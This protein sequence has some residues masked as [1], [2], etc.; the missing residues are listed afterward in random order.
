MTARARS[1]V[2]SERRIAAWAASV[3]RALRSDEAWAILDADPATA[4]GTW[5]HG[6]CLLLAKA[7]RATLGAGEV[8]IVTSPRRGPGDRVEHA[9]LRL[10]N[11]FVDAEGV[12]SE[13]ALLGRMARREMI[14]SP[15][16]RR[17]EQGDV[18][19]SDVAAPRASVAALAALLAD[20]MKLPR[21]NGA[22]ATEREPRGVRRAAV[23]I[24]ADGVSDSHGVV[25]FLGRSSA[26][27][28]RIEGA[29][30]AFSYARRTADDLLRR[31]VVPEVR[32]SFAV[33]RVEHRVEIRVRRE[34]GSIMALPWH[35][36]PRQNPSRGG[37]DP[38][39]R[40]KLTRD[41]DGSNGIIAMRAGEQVGFL[42]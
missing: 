36:T 2:I 40:T 25:T 4:G 14:P 21:P 5:L 35:E 32:I 22:L 1:G 37:A 10:G 11:V 24:M 15:S 19:R 39:L 13:R 20:R 34:D 9:V 41:A 18:T 17:L 23:V 26:G 16:L 28:R 30:E 33:E 8:W 42:S 27:R 12:S 3:A 7:L 29:A 38:V 31:G 6:G